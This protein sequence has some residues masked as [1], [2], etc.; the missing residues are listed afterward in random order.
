[1]LRIVRRKLRMIRYHSAARPHTIWTRAFDWAMIGS[2]LAALP[3]TGLC[4]LLVVRSQIAQEQAGHLSQTESGAIVAILFDGKGAA[5][6][7]STPI[8]NFQL[9][10][11]EVSCGWPWPTSLRTL[12]AQLDIDIVRE[13]TP[14]RNVRLSEDDP[15]RIGIES[16]LA[17]GDQAKALESLRRTA[18]VVRRHWHSW[19]IGAAMWWIMLVFA[20][21]LVIS[22]AKFAT[23]LAQRRI[24]AR[25]ARR[26]AAGKCLACG[27]DMTGL[28]FNEKCPECGALVW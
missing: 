28:E 5:P 24:A 9:R 4:N 12:P 13:T 22:M 3:I 6:A 25:R 26:R 17:A 27:Y 14:R 19:A 23:Q 21:S 10:V 20:S 7:D 2:L 16:A 15:L 18:P 8:G 1:M 11:N